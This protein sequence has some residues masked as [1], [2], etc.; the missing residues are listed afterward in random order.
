MSD[1]DARKNA[2][3]SYDAALKAIR[4]E[5]IKSGEINPIVREVTIG[6][7]RL[8]QG[9][10][11]AIMPTL[12]KVDAV[13]TDPPYG[14]LD[15]AWDAMNKTE[16]AAF[17]MQWAGAARKISDRAVVFFGQR[18]R[19]TIQDI[20]YLIYPEIRQVI[21]AKGGGTVA[22]DGMFY[23]YESAYFCKPTSEPETLVGPKSMRF[24]AAL[25]ACRQRAKMSRGQVDIAVRGKKQGFVTGGKRGVAC[26]Q[27][28]SC[29]QSP[30]R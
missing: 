17:T 22:D 24:A 18:T 23:S 10:C 3:E 21:W 29:P 4:L 30:Q 19:Q 13:V 6:D 2:A 16:L 20:L 9:D 25:K 7:C 1:Y 12:G 27:M 26:R 15:E 28:T 8:I 14:V 5:K 11:L